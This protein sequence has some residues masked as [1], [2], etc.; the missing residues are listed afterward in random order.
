M[1]KFSELVIKHRKIVVFTTVFITLVLG[2]CLKDLTINADITSY[3]PKSDPV[4]KLFNYIGEEYGGNSLAMVALETDDIFNKET[5]E[6]LN[7]LTSQFKLL[8]GVSYV[9]SLANV[10]DIKKGEDG[11]EIGRLIDEYALPKTAKE[12]QKLKKYTLSKD[13]YRG[14]L[15]SD[16]AKATLIICRLN[17]DV[18]KIE[19]AKQL[20]EIIKKLELKEKVYFGGIP[21]QMIDISDIILNDMRVLIPF[22][23]LLIFISLFLSFRTLRGVFL[24]ILSVLISTIWTLGIMSVLKIPLT[25]ISNIIPVI[26]IAVGSAYSIHVISKFNEESDVDEDKLNHSKRA[27]KEIGIPVILAAVTTTAGFM[28]FVFGSYLSMIQEFGIFAG[29]G[30]L[31][32]LLISITFVP[33]V[34]SLLSFKNKTAYLNDNIKKKDGITRFMDKIGEWVLKNEKKIIAAG[35][36]V[37]IISVLGIP[38]IQRKVDM[39]DYFKH[40]SSIRLTEEIMQNKFGG[41]IPIQILVKGDIQDPAVLAEMKKMENFLESLDDVKNSQSVADLIEEMS[42]VMGEGKVIPDSKDKVCNLWFLLEGEEVMSQLVNDDKTEAIIQATIASVNTKQMRNLVKNIEKYINRTKSSSFTFTQ[43][44]MPSIYQHL[45]DSMMQ[46]QIQSL[47][48]AIILVF[49]CLVFLLRSFIGGLIGLVPIGFTLIVVFGFMGFSGIPLD[50]AT[51]LVGSISIGIGI[52]YSIHFVSRF[53][54][55]FKKDKTELEALD[56]TLETSGKAILIN[57]ITVML[58]FLVLVL[59]NLIPLRRFGILVAITMIGS[60][61]SAITLLPSIILATKA[62]FIGDFQRFINMSKNHFMNKNKS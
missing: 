45:D 53:R 36:V 9:T 50:I 48:I 52:D 10:L 44:G 35:I 8:D 14:R 55:E 20:K 21:F 2:Y 43:T 32:S 38:K 18:G 12:L 29:L 7:Y 60:G 33:S 27:L 19:T 31:F 4:V 28:A 46:S 40:G 49:I 15:I 56:R 37:V 58:G 5:I 25:V 17:G 59:A 62:G 47:I 54:K 24:P 11:I 13:M 34:L 57:V 1:K 16:D 61:V 51:V 22:I 39:L 6:Q 30:V 23:L 26:L 3:L 42:D 41:S